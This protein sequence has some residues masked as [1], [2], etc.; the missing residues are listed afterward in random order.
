MLTFK[1]IRQ[2]VMV[3]KLEIIK[4]DAALAAQ[5]HMTTV[6]V[7]AKNS[8]DEALSGK[9]VKLSFIDKSEW[10][11]VSIE[12]KD[13]L[14]INGYATFTI[15]SNSSYPIAL[16]QQGINLKAVYADNNEIFAQ[17]TI[18]VITNDTDVSDKLAL[19][20][21][22]DASSYELMLK[23]IRLPLLFKVLI[24]KVKQQLKVKFLYL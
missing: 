3:Q 6:K 17:D 7:R 11:G 20:A 10:S 14:Q 8:N 21:L 13:R 23:K 18:S 1:D 4:A 19:Q 24:T 12:P 9:L 2:I 22:V 16:S 5:G 15:K